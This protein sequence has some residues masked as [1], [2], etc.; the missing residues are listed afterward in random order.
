MKLFVFGNACD[1][2]CL[3]KLNLTR[4][5]SYTLLLLMIYQEIM[6]W[7]LLVVLLQMFSGMPVLGLIVE[8]MILKIIMT[9]I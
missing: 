3:H 8:V 1:V 6:F 9:D 7:E 5:V 2:V 4:A